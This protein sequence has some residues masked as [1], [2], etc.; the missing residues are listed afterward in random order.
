MK[1]I[2]LLGLIIVFVSAVN[3]EAQTI[4]TIAG[5]GVAGFSGD[6]STATN[7][8]IFGP[9]GVAV[10]GAGNEYISDYYNQR[11]RKIN[12]SG[13]ITTVA[14]TG[15]A[16]YNGDGMAATE[17][18]INYPMGIAADAFGNVYFAD[19]GNNR[20]RMISASGTITTLAGTGTGGYSGDN[21]PAINAKL[22]GPTGVAVDAA[23]NVFIADKSNNVIRRV[24]AVSGMITTV[25][26][27]G[28]PGYNG[29]SWPSA[30]LSDLD[31]PADVALDIMGNLY[32]ADQ[33]NNRVR[34]VDTFRK[35]STI[36]GNG[37][38][39]YTADGLS[40][41]S[42]EIFSPSSVAVDISGNVYISD[43]LNYMIRKVD[44][45]SNT[46][47]T[48]AG[49]RVSGFNGDTGLAVNAQIGDC[50]GLAVDHAGNIYFS[51]WRYNRV[52]FITSTITGVKEVNG[53]MSAIAVYPN[54]NSG[55]FT[56]NVSSVNTERMRLTITNLTGEK[57]KE[58]TAETNK[59]VAI[60]LNV[61][62]GIYFI[63]ANSAGGNLTTKVEIGK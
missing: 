16:G 21:G 51:D 15:T 61:A 36:F 63:S 47:V 31:N 6:T 24:D 59:P 50:K 56:V 22:Y 62:A 25:A 43:E 18:K 17:A 2:V 23:G 34:M 46:V 9:T 4:F 32:I 26:G 30:T 42:S 19:R 11:I 5:N 54:P 35:I 49:N 40:A 58:I 41:T 12:S 10:D 20:V 45:N 53:D 13:T 48:I 8:E 60:D 1:K 28:A 38:G 52:N 14:G 33:G 3:T 44:H 29:D 55:V 57:I 37:I 27:T 39:G 7:A